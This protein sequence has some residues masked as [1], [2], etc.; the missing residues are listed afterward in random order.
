MRLVRLLTYIFSVINVLLA[1]NY[2]PLVPLLGWLNFGHGD[3]ATAWIPDAVI[4]YVLPGAYFF[5]WHFWYV[6]AVPALLGSL[7]LFVRTRSRLAGVLAVVNGG[8]VLV[9]WAVRIILNIAGI[10][11]DIV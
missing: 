2:F 1:L 11:P 7:Y 9:Y 3:W 8:A 4:L 10:R 5:Y 6:A